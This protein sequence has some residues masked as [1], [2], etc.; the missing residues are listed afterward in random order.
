MPR[1][2]PPPPPHGDDW[3]DVGASASSSAPRPPQGT[4]RGWL[5]PPQNPTPRASAPSSSSPPPRPAA[6]S[7]STPPPPPPTPPPSSLLR[8]VLRRFHEASLALVTA[9]LASA[10]RVRAALG[11]A[12]TAAAAGLE[13]YLPAPKN[14]VAALVAAT[15]LALAAR[16]VRTLRVLR[17]REKDCRAMV[18]AL[19]ALH[20]AVLSASGVGAG[21][22][23]TAPLHPLLSAAG[24]TEAGLAKAVGGE[25][26]SLAAVVLGEVAPAGAG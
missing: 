2:S 24:Y 17:A 10:A 3:E 15:F 25:A 6:S 5:R 26:A 16:H 1:T 14:R 9:T 8:S 11:A 20:R 4:L 22:A 21:G 18:G 13:P 12:A 23:S 7:S 19:A